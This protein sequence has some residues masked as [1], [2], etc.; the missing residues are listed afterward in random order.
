MFVDFSVNYIIY[1]DIL[2][3]IVWLISVLVFLDTGY[4]IKNRHI[5][6]RAGPFVKKLRISSITKIIVGKTPSSGSFFATGRRGLI[7]YYEHDKDIYISPMTNADFLKC[8]KKISPSLH[9]KSYNPHVL[10]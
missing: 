3:L 6:L 1:F 8:L 9:I 4:N 10:K 5:I 7:I 2:T